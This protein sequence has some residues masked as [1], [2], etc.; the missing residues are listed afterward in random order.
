MVIIYIQH[1]LLP[2]SPSKVTLKVIKQQS[3][4]VKLTV[5]PNMT[6]KN[7][8][9]TLVYFCKTEHKY[10]LNRV[11]IRFCAVGAEPTVQLT[12]QTAAKVTTLHLLMTQE[13][14]ENNINTHRLDVK[15]LQLCEL[16]GAGLQRLSHDIRHHRGPN[17]RY[18]NK[19][20]NIHIHKIIIFR[21]ENIIIREKR[22][23]YAFI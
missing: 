23:G 3:G 18:W 8:A 5:S 7:N 1:R 20:V 2:P 19:K 12:L 9:I 13:H 16:R 15:K 17:M 11:N 14:T 10:R 21:L 6:Y 4:S 22:K